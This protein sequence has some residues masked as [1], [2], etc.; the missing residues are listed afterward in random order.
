MVFNL[1]LKNKKGENGVI[2]IEI[3]GAQKVESKPNH[4]Q[5]SIT[6]SDYQAREINAVSPLQSSSLHALSLTLHSSLARHHR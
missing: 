5:S 3:M 2:K 6:S 1:V 4:F